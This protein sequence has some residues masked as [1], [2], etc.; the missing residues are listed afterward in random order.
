[1]S[2]VVNIQEAKTNLS[3]LVA[4]SLAGEEVIIA[5]RG[6]AMVR[7]VPYIRPKKRELGFA[8]GDENWDDA[9]FETLSEE[10]LEAWSL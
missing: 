1:M 10:E 9:F 7:L 4:A 8:G 6:T 2:V 5:N 3:K